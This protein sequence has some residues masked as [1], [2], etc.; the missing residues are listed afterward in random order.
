MVF[1][2]PT[3]LRDRADNAAMTTQRYNYLRAEQLARNPEAE[4]EIDMLVRDYLGTTPPGIAPR[5]DDVII[6]A[7]PISELRRV[8]GPV[9]DTDIPPS[10]A[11][12]PPP[13]QG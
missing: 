7:A 4:P 1:I 8:D 5:G 2:R 13:P 6:S 11:A 10:S 3:I 9:T 12:P